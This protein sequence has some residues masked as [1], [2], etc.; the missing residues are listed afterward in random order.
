MADLDMS[1]EEFY[2]QC[3]ELEATWIKLTDDHKAD[4]RLTSLVAQAGLRG[5]WD[6]L[7]E[8]DFKPEADDV[9]AAYAIEQLVQKHSDMIITLFFASGEARKLI[10]AREVGQA[11]NGLHGT[12]CLCPGGE[13][14]N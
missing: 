7:V 5:M 10:K 13:I 2:R 12:Y 8:N 14:H 1:K 4:V 3:E 6:T 9:R 11:P